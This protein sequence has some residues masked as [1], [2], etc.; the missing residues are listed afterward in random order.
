MAPVIDNLSPIA[1]VLWEVKA[2][3]SVCVYASVQLQGLKG[4]ERQAFEHFSSNWLSEM[5]KCFVEHF[6]VTGRGTTYF[7]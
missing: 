6:V 3:V 5:K 2:Q 4:D 7:V 1:V